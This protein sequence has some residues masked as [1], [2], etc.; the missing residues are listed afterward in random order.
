MQPELSNS[1]P[2]TVDKYD[3]GVNAAGIGET[4]STTSSG[5]GKQFFRDHQGYYTNPETYQIVSISA[6]ESSDEYDGQLTV[7]KGVRQSPDAAGSEVYNLVY[8][9]DSTASIIDEKKGQVL[10]RGTVDFYEGG[11]YISWDTGA[12]TG[13]YPMGRP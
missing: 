8:I 11:I 12:L 4:D 2:S 3:Y 7:A 5:D 13:D 9:S 10:D 1:N 6:Y